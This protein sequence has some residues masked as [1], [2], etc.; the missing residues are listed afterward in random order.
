[1]FMM[2]HQAADIACKGRIV[3]GVIYYCSHDLQHLV[4]AFADIVMRRLGQL[5]LNA[6]TRIA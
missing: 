1:M 6:C 5:G 3:D 2:S 4:M